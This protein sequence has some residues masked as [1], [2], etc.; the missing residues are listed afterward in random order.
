[1]KLKKSFEVS[2][3]G[4]NVNVNEDRGYGLYPMILERIYDQITN[5][6]SYYSRITV[7]RIDLHFPDGHVTDNKL[8]NSWLSQYI[9]TCKADLGSSVWDSHKRLVHGWVKEVGSTG[10]SHYHLFF[11]F[12]TQHRKLGLISY[13]GHTGMWE[14]FERRWKQIT[15]GSVHFS[16][17]HFLMRDNKK[18]FE[19]CFYHLSYLAKI[20][21]KHFGTGEPYRRFGSS[22]LPI[23]AKALSV[24]EE[25]MVA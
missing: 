5:L 15:G 10:K 9:K 13:D 12:K 1:M 19:E 17:P 18:L 14:M 8:E 16:K 25:L 2:Y 4:I 20:R 7:V 23:K 11:G 24:L 22:R 21:D 3:K 6:Q